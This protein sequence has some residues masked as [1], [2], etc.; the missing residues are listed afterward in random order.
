M[1][2]APTPQPAQPVERRHAITFTASERVKQKLD[3]ARAL[4]SHRLRSQHVED[5][6][7]APRSHPRD[8]LSP[9]AARRLRRRLAVAASSARAGDE[10]AEHGADALTLSN[11][12]HGPPRLVREPS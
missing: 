1:T 9:G 10:A 11:G 2:L 8:A 7:G 3:R 5:V 6:L 12:H 4:A